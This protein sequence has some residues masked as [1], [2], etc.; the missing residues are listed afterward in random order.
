MVVM[1]SGPEG[2]RLAPI[3]PHTIRR[4]TLSNGI[5]LI[6]QENHVSPSVVVRGHLWVGAI[7]DPVEKM[8][9]SRFTALGVGRGTATRTFQE[10]NELTESVGANVFVSGGRHLTSFGGKSLIED[11]DLLVDI[12]SDVLQHPVFPQREV[13]KVRGQLVTGLKELEDDTRGLASREFRQLLYTLD[14]PYGRPVDGTLET[15]PA[16]QRADLESFYQT[17]YHP[18]DASIVVVGDVQPE[19]VRDKLDKALG[20]W[21]PDGDGQAFEVPAVQTLQVQ[22][23]HVRTMTNKTQADIALGTIGPSRFADVYYAARLGDLILGQLG[24]MGRLGE[25]VR[26][27]RGLAYY[28]YSGMEAGLG[29]GPWS[30]RA[31]VNPANVDEAIESIVAEIK[32]LRDEPVTD[33]ELEDGKDYVTGSLPLRLET[34]EGIASTL[35]DIDLYQL[36]DD[37]IMR[38]ESIMRSVTKEQIQAAAQEYLD[39]EHY[40]LTVVGPYEETK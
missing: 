1:T 8:G 33:A 35:L 40:A 32:R 5:K 25:K 17:Y 9:L 20:D 39:P 11:F 2:G 19:Q 36:G 12:L 23:R 37:Y 38:Y 21:Q 10:I 18:R 26:D 15:I 3:G 6:V 27:E 13:D 16:I 29:R 4:F 14:H 30:V 28:A 22:L 34:N 31:G 24:L 7:H